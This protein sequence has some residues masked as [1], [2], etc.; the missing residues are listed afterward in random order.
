M[1]ATIV[2]KLAQVVI[3]SRTKISTLEIVEEF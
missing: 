3:Q 1:V 2:D